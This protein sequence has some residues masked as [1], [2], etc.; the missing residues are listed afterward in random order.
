VSSYSSVDLVRPWRT[1]TLV[2]SALA[3]VE[4]VALVGVGFAVLAK[5]L[6]RHMHHA[7]V[8]RALAPAPAAKPV[9]PAPETPRLARTETS[10][11]VLN[12]NGVAGA[13]AGSA[14]RVRGLGYIVGSV[15]NA[16]KSDHTRS[17]VMF[18]PG[19][20]PEAKRLAHDLGIAI[21]GPLAGMQ[22]AD[23]M[24]AHLALV[25]GS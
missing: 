19:Y 2:A 11:M 17:L 20:E 24:G 9:K 21:V 18:R 8:T 14:A 13:A 5:P 22:P 10:V 7:A 4:L 1:A 12:G 15:G 3:A 6:S 25:V 16:P 23:L